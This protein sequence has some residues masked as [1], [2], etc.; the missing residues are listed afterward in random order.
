MA[1]NQ[2]EPIDKGFRA[3]VHQRK[4][5]YGAGPKPQHITAGAVAY[6]DRNGVLY[7]KGTFADDIILL[8]RDSRSTLRIDIITTVP[9]VADLGVAIISIVVPLNTFHNISIDAGDGEDTVRVKGLSFKPIAAS[10]ESFSVAQPVAPAAH[11]S[12]RRQQ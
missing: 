2:P 6:V 11:P 3:A 10:V 8:H 9:N 4:L 5:Y 12:G 7:L 1:N